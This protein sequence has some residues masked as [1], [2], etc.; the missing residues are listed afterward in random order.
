MLEAITCIPVTCAAIL[1]EPLFIDARAVGDKGIIGDSDVIDKAQVIRTILRVRRWKS[2]NRRRG[3]S[4]DNNNFLSRLNNQRGFDEGSFGSRWA[5]GRRC[6]FRRTSRKGEK[7]QSNAEQEPA[8]RDAARR[9]KKEGRPA[10][11]SPNGQSYSSSATVPFPPL[12]PSSPPP[13]SRGKAI[14]P[15]RAFCRITVSISP[16][17]SGF[18]RK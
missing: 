15:L 9:H 10:V 4:L 5:E 2:S 1:D 3:R 7:N 18:W 8:W 16:I 12:P 6:G 14:S 11:E 13:I 17:R